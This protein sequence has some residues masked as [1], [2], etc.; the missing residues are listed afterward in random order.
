MSII[1]IFL[2]LLVATFATI[3]YFTEPSEA[4][5]RTQERLSGLDRP[6][7]QGED[8]RAEI[9]RRV[10]FSRI[11]W[12]DRYLRQNKPAL[13]L[14]LWLEQSKVPWTVGRFFFFSSFLMVIGA[15]IGSWWIPVGFVGWIPGLILGLVPLVYVGFQRSRRF[16]RFNLLLPE[17]IDLIA[18]AL[19]AG[20]SLPSALVTVAEEV[21]DPLGPEFQRCADEMNYGLPFREA[22]HNLFRRFP[23]QDLQF[24]ISAILIQRETGGNLPELL[25][26]TAGVLRSRIQ[27]QQKVRVHTAQGRLTG[28]VLIAMPFVAFVLLN[29]V[30]PGYTRPLFDSNLGH[31]MIYFTL[32]SMMLG[33]IVI[34]KIIR[35]KY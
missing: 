23:I 24:L 29:L 14:Q 6:V 34:R 33:T 21:A 18:R 7:M 22:M 25:D 4:E 5:K 17:A 19:R 20:H 16:Q 32:I 31:K 1:S 10:T 9:V 26:K 2:I 15:V 27:L 13:Q 35:V 8:D 28:A 30:R 11:S 3:A 12:L